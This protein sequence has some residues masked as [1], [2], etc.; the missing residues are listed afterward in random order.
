LRVLVVGGS[1]FIGSHLVDKLLEKGR[2]VRVF[3]HAPERFRN[4]PS[5][6]E[7]V[8]GEFLDIEQ[9]VPALGG[10]EVVYHLVGMTLPETSNRDMIFDL[11][12][13]V[14]ATIRLL[15]KCVQNKVKRVVF[16]SSGGTVYGIPRELP[17][18][19]E[20]ATL[21][22]CAYGVSK[23]A[24]EK[25]LYV[26]SHL[27]G[28]EFAVARPA[29]P[30]GERQDPRGIQGALN[31]FLGKVARAEN[32]EIWGDGEVVRDYF[33]VGDL[34]DALEILGWHSEARNG[35][36]NIGSGKGLSLNQ[37]IGKIS[38][39]TGKNP[40]VNYVESRKIDVPE[41][42]LKVDKIRQLGW[43]NVTSFEEGLIRT[44][45]WIKSIT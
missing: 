41:I 32:I 19:E 17:I 23:L 43:Q 28:L 10:V 9:V 33:Y 7:F 36:F 6:V 30:F 45:E 37:L 26:F 4:R 29:N 42:V 38:E 34:A 44:W 31:V 11:E 22:I 2:E 20:A 40:E 8:Q 1:G 18:G 25:Y 3:D 13:N 27:Y 39:V 14:G 35:V 15:R 5:D 21:P 16:N 24:I 12:S